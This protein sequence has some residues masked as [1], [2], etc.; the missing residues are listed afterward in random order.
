MILV[1]LVQLIKDPSFDDEYYEWSDNR[2]QALLA[3]D[4]QSQE[5][6]ASSKSDELENSSDDEHVLNISKEQPIDLI[7]QSTPA[8][9]PNVK[10]IL[11]LLDNKQ[12]ALTVLIDTEAVSLIIYGSSNSFSLSHSFCD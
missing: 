1:N 9:R 2:E 10:V 7:M 5:S 8:F 6:D 12:I 3:I 11:Q 4:S